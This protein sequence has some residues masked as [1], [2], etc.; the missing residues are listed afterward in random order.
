MGWNPDEARGHG[1]H[2]AQG[3]QGGASTSSGH[4][5]GWNPDDDDPGRGGKGDMLGKLMKLMPK[6]VSG[7]FHGLFEHLT[8]FS[9]KIAGWAEKGASLLGKGMHFAE[10]GM[11][12]LSAIEK[13]AEKV[14]GFAG[15]AEGFLG[16]MG[17]GKLAGFAG[18]IGGAAGWVDKEAKLLH[19]GLKTADKW[20]GKG[21]KVA[22][23][24]DSAAKKAGGIFDDAG[25]DR[26]GSLL[27]L[28]KASKNGDGIDG[29]LAPEKMRLGSNL[30]EPRR[31]DLMTMSRM[32]GFLGGD[33]AGVRIHTGPG[34]AHVTHRFAA[35]A[36]TVK[37]HI[38]FAPG[39]FNPSTI[40]GQRL[41]AHELTHV[42]QKG[43]PNLDVRTAESEALH[44]EH[45]F[46]YGNPQ[47]ETL[48]L[49]QPSPD[50]RLADGEGLGN[51]SGVHT[52]KR[53]RS[54][55]H[56]AGGKDTLPDGEEF[57]EQVSG[58]VY[59]LLMEEL[60]HAFESR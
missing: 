56:E 36:V 42:M 12:G 15:K 52:A 39:R 47:M 27:S 26:F 11:H 10:M 43:R 41:L 45:S 34:A 17:L 37:D 48:N 40:E 31:L 49:S 6:K 20:M 4:G 46:G 1:G 7:F 44:S 24:V 5:M 58:R 14:Q 25:H 3:G 9:D 19:G 59:E 60:E 35:E 8:A 57:I 21:K 29:R 23:Q 51:S 2:G 28:F 54:K 38:F 53:N 22:G 30:D 55:G 13:A 33:F 16:K 18:K 32:E 50:F